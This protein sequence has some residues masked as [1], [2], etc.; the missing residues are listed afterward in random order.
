MKTRVSTIPLNDGS[1][2]TIEATQI[3]RKGKHLDA[4]KITMLDN[5]G[6]EVPGR[7]RLEEVPEGCLFVFDEVEDKSQN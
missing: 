4:L 3:E 1:C 6:Q 5:T 7:G 2:W